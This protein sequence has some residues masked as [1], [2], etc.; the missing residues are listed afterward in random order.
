MDLI[1][2]VLE[3]KNK[4][5]MKVKI[6][7]KIYCSSNEPIML[8]FEN[9]SERNVVIQHLQNMPEKATKYC[10]YPDNVDNE[11]AREFMKIE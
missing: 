5:N 1:N 4:N 6:S 8:I 10:I 11:V 3:K 7:D 9:I 2:G